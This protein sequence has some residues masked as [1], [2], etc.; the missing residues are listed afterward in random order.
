MFNRIFYKLYH[1]IDHKENNKW[2]NYPFGKNPIGTSAEYDSLAKST[3]K[4][5]YPEI[6]N[7]ERECGYAIDQE[8]LNELALKTQIVIKNSELC[9]QHGRV[10]Y[11][12][13]STYINNHLDDL[14][15]R[16]Y[17]FF[18]IKNII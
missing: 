7:F 18:T 9:F 12:A 1:I 11:S 15:N 10:L 16:N 14:Y 3:F 17:D 13:L 8:W 2:Y 5:S 6:D 4:K